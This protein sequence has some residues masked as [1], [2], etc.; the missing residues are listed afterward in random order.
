ML[1]PRV[2]LSYARADRAD[3]DA[4]FVQL[5]QHG[6]RVWMDRHEILAGDDFVHSLRQHVARSDAL[7]FMLTPASAASSWC[8]AELQFALGRGITPIVVRRSPDSQL[9]EAV[10]RLLRDIQAV[11]WS[12]APAQLGTQIR[13]ARQRSRRRVLRLACLGLGATGALAVAAQQAIAGIN[14][15]DEQRKR[16]RFIDDLRVAGQV[17]SGDEVRS[18]LRPVRDD[19]QLAGL[20]GDISQD[21][22]QPI[23]ARVNAW[24]ALGALHEGRQAEWRTFV[25][26][27]DW[28]GGRLANQLWANTTYARG[29]IQGL[30]ANRVRI[31]GLVFGKSPHEGKAGMSLLGVRASDCD[32]W[33]LRLD[34]TQLID[35]EFENCKFRGAQLDLSAAAG[36]RMVS[37]SRSQTFLS[38]DLTIV[39]D[40]WLVQR[41]P[42]PGPGVLDLAVPA[43]ELIF[44]GVQFARVR[45][46]GHFKAAWFN[47]CHF[48][49]CVFQTGLT[50]AALG[51]GG[52]SMEGSDFRSMPE[53]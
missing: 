28:S 15:F 50:A 34:G 10:Q 33:F 36:A 2:F 52:N 32:I 13:K 39:E 12:D 45:F 53:V 26:E 11:A 31:A 38:T 6:C 47:R 25:P 14:R 35:V 4:L 16:R 21:A 1:D 9:P 27:I 19:P 30:Q 40:S 42:P 17:W 51:A 29:R 7:V 46:E 3:A 8:L 22:A 37:R 43:Q 24:Q 23:L 44:D 18:R 41:R 49:Q 5:E 20:L 48:T